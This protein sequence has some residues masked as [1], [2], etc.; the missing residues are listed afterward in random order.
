[1]LS[2]R[3]PDDQESQ[4]IKRLDDTLGAWKMT[5]ESIPG[6]GNCCFRAVA[7]S[8]IINQ[9]V[10]IEHADTFF[11]HLGI[12]ISRI[13]QSDFAMKLRDLVVS[14]WQRNPE[15]CQGFLTDTTVED[16]A[17]LFRSSGYFNS[18][19]GDTVLL[20]LSNVLGVSIIVFTSISGN[21]VINIIPQYL[22]IP[23][24]IHL[25]YLQY[26][27]RHYDIA[28]PL[29]RVDDVD[30]AKPSNLHDH[31]VTETKPLH[32]TCGKNEKG[33]HFNCIVSRWNQGMLQ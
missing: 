31:S 28:L 1:M 10:I 32:C 7:S 8:L 17:E 33:E 13:N 11:N 30:N 4:H 12:D 14:E 25:A 6:D 22:R 21:S 18:E 19:L 15:T 16:E 29:T 24:S 20:T 3:S 27:S 23:V 5:R 2:I 26:G 9:K